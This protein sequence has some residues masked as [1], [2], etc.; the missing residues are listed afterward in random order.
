[1]EYDS[2]S[3]SESEDF[4]GD[5]LIKNIEIDPDKSSFIRSEKSFSK[6]GQKKNIRNPAGKT[7]NE[8]E[9]ISMILN[10]T[11]RFSTTSPQKPEPLRSANITIDSDDENYKYF[12]QGSFEPSEMNPKVE[13]FQVYNTMRNYAY[14]YG[15]QLREKGI[16]TL[17]NT[18]T[19]VRDFNPYFFL[20][21]INKYALTKVYLTR[22]YNFTAPFSEELNKITDEQYK[23]FALACIVNKKRI[24]NRIRNGKIVRWIDVMV[25]KKDLEGT[26]IQLSW[27]KDLDFAD[28][29]NYEAKMPVLI[30]D[31]GTLDE[32][33]TMITLGTDFY[34]THFGKDDKVINPTIELL[35]TMLERQKRIRGEKG[36]S[37]SLVEKKK[38]NQR[39]RDI[40]DIKTNYN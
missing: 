28:Y 40:F 15:E 30:I 24:L 14:A 35:R 12:K 4:K 5:T 10:R 38:K 21:F 13:F 22:R 17:K 26:D 36:E 37:T 31:C 16:K 19:I 33:P 1:M 23:N 3:N 18:I 20:G 27:I 2:A 39:R 6:T 25:E 29:I 7:C 34:F 8:K 32:Q 9:K 11:S